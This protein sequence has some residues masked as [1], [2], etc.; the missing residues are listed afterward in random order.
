[1]KILN[2]KLREKLFLQFSFKIIEIPISLILKIAKLKKYFKAL[3][4]SKI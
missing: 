2:E 3:I 4:N 1:M